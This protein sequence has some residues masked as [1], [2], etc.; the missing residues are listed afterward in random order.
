MARVGFDV[1][2][3]DAAFEELDAR[4]LAGEAAAHSRAWSVIMRTFAALNRHELLAT[5][6]DW[7]NIDHRPLAMF[8]AGD[9][10]TYLRATWDLTPDLSDH[11]E[12]VH[13]LS[14]LGAVVTWAAYGTSEK[15]FDAEWRGAN[16]MTVEGELISRC[17]VFDEAD[18]DAA[19]ARFDELD[20]PAP[21]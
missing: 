19:L 3:V 7:I 21:T 1:D 5:T 9:L 15:G 13:R 2:D 16:V 17:E 4:Y 14:N 12:V 18:L 20:R 11:I 8:K 10:A 6:P